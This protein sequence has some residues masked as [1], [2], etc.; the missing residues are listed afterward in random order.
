MNKLFFVIWGNPKFYQTLI[1]L[2]RH[3]S[4]KG[5]KIV[6][7]C[8]KYDSQ[9]DII[10]KTDFGKNTQIFFAPNNFFGSLNSLNYLTFV[11]YVLY[12][13]IKLSPKNIIFFNQKSLFIVILINF[14]F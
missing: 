5:T 8:K 1:F 11:V 2:A 3:L 9:S 12:N 6:I 13:Q 4:K 7:L 10:E 14:F